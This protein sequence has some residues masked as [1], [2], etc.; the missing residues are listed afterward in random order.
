MPLL[1]TI[2]SGGSRGFGQFGLVPQTFTNIQP[3]SYSGSNQT[4]IVPNGVTKLRTYCWGAAGG[5]GYAGG[6][7]SFNSSGGFGGAGGYSYGEILVTPGSTLLI[8]VGQGGVYNPGG[9]SGAAVAPYGHANP[10]LARFPGVAAS[11]GNG[12]GLSGVFASNSFTQAN[13]LLIAGGGGGGSGYGIYETSGANNIRGGGGGGANLPGENGDPQQNE[14]NAFGR[15]A[16]TTA[17]GAPGSDFYRATGGGTTSTGNNSFAGGALYGGTAA[18]VASWTEGG[19]G[20][21]GYWGGGPGNHDSAGGR[22]GNGGGGSG[23][24][25]PGVLNVVGASASKSII[26]STATSAPNYASGI[27]VPVAGTTGGNGRVVLV[28]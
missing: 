11:G 8:V 12:G 27:G 3:F 14:F 20:G 23:Y 2:G 22:W 4:F 17:G 21:S 9:S 19:G 6:G 18:S 1:E 5:A 7:S 26:S 24:A 15:G 10:S 25:A 28:Y 16:S 13:A